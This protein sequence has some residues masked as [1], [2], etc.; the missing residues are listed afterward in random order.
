M[1]VLWVTRT[2]QYI[3]DACHLEGHVCIE[4]VW[5]KHDYRIPSITQCKNKV[6]KCLPTIKANNNSNSWRHMGIETVRQGTEA[7]CFFTSQWNNTLKL[8]DELII[9]KGPQ[10][11]LN[12]SCLVSSPKPRCLL[13]S[14]MILGRMNNKNYRMCS[15]KHLICTCSNHNWRF[16]Q[17]IFFL[18]LQKRRKYEVLVNIICLQLSSCNGIN[19]LEQWF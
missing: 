9:A 18:Q 11:A 12:L 2:N 3:S 5:S 16:H 15:G 4:I 7:N 13:I 19:G 6:H 1:K 8:I 10:K 17:L 14:L